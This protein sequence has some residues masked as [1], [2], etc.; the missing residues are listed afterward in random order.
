MYLC[1]WSV[2]QVTADAEVTQHKFSFY[3]DLQFNTH[4]TVF[5]NFL[6]RFYVWNLRLRVIVFKSREANRKH[7][8][9]Q[10]DGGV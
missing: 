4:R 10:S 3:D 6:L 7:E 5:L 8:E 9:K 2:S 1:S